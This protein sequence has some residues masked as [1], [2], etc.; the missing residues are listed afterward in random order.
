MLFRSLLDPPLHEFLPHEESEFADV[1]EAAGVGIEVLKQRAMELHEV[2]PMLGH[3]GCR[4]GVTYP[5]STKCRR[6]RYLKQRVR[7]RLLRCP[8]S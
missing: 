3:R 1:A 4:L 2:N 5:K 6:A 7:W 8:K